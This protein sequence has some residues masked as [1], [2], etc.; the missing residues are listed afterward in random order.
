METLMLALLVLFRD[1]TYGGK[2]Q[3]ACAAAAADN[4]H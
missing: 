3:C 2:S 1:V 4:R